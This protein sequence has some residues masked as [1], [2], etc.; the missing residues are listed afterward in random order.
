MRAVYRLL[1]LFLLTPLVVLADEFPGERLTASDW[2]MPR[3]GMRLLQ[4]PPVAAAVERLQ[5][6]GPDSRLRVRYAGGDRGTLWARD[7]QSWLV[8]LGIGSD[9]IEL[10]P[11]GAD[12]NTLELTVVGAEPAA[13][14]D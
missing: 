1:P 14:K 13:G 3:S 8:A 10:R 9:R 11:G 2:A 6:A 4:L 5:A 12:E 7:L